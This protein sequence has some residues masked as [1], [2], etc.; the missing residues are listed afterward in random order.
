LA[1]RLSLDL[2]LVIAYSASREI[3]KPL[4]TIAKDFHTTVCV[5]NGCFD[6]KQ[7]VNLFIPSL[8]GSSSSFETMK[9][10]KCNKRRCKNCCSGYFLTLKY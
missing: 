5:V 10:G 1:C 6:K 2:L 8:K 4:T 7:P 9:I 3:N